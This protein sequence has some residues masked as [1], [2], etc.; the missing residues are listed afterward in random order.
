MKPINKEKILAKL[1]HVVVLK[2]GTSVERDISLLS[3]SAVFNG[4]QRLGVNA[5]EIDVGKD[6]IDQLKAAQPDLVLN[7]LHGKDGEDGVI[8]GL[9]EIL[10]FPY[11]G[12]GVLA[13]AIAMDKVKSKLIWQRLGLNTAE[14]EF[15]S[16]DTDWQGL[17]NKFGK[18][19]VKPVNGG[20]S[21][22]IAIVD[23]AA[24]LEK[25]YQS[26]LAFDSDVIAEKFISG[27]EYSTGVLGDELFPTV[28]LETPREF[29]DY[30]AKY[31]DENTKYICPPELSSEKLSEL[32]SLVKEAYDSLGCTGLARIDLMQ[33][34]DGDFYLLELN[35]IPGMTNHSFVPMA[36][37]QVGISFDELVLRILDYEIERIR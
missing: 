2:G 8:Q 7:M 32:E 10:G 6:I 22:G 5:S 21:L 1:G 34:G 4:L 28:Q 30:E 26:A 11:T 19:V 23:N 9:L 25:Q 31:E 17:I 37:K 3:G 16:T 18:V 15:I 36:A 13:S 35:T 24:D 29:F 20:S 33:E 12:S 14:F 27:T